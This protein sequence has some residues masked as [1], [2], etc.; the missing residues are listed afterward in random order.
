[1][2]AHK[3]FVDYRPQ[4]VIANRC[5]HVHFVRGAEAVEEMKKRYASFERR[6]MS[7]RREIA[8]LLDGIRG[9]QRKSSGACSHH[10]AMIAK[11]R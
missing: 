8:G 9:K 5:N 6:H 4:I 7:N 3:F 2:L 1:M 11:N 10:I